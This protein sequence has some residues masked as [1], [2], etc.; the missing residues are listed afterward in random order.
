[1]SGVAEGRSVASP[2]V[3]RAAR[4]LREGSR[5]MGP[6]M[7]GKA[8]CARRRRQRLWVGVAVAMVL[9]AR[10]E[11]ARADDST[12]PPAP[13]TPAGPTTTTSELHLHVGGVPQQPLQPGHDVRV[14]S[15]G[16]GTRLLA[17]DTTGVAGEGQQT[18]RQQ[19]CVAPCLAKL[20]PS[21]TYMIRGWGLSDSAHF[22]ISDQTAEVH[23]HTG[24]AAVGAI[25]ATSMSLGVLGLVGG[26]VFVPFALAQDAQHASTRHTFLTAG[27]AAIG[28]GVA[29]VVL[30][31]VLG[32][33]STT[34]VYDGQGPRL[35]LGHGLRLTPS[36]LVF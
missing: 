26:A 9:A 6:T 10:V 24:S 18:P 14:T 28:G 31:V 13:V 35:A 33:A 3:V 25:G 29:L 34:H 32:L 11:T 30:G 36:G 20:S 2:T 5:V 27:E 4:L 19:V 12:A 15:D 8:R 21:T 1:L 23:V 22:G 7:D 17:V 16:E